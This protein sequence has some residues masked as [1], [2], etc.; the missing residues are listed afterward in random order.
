[1]PAVY[2]EHLAFCGQTGYALTDEFTIPLYESSE[3]GTGT[4]S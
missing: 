3:I 2:K 4:L 1:M